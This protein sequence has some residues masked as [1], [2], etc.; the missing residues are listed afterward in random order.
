MRLEYLCDMALAYREEPLY[1]TDFVLVQPYGS[2]EGSGY[3]EMDGTV[4]GDRLQGRVRVANHPHARSDGTF[5]PN[6]HGVIVTDDQATIL[7]SL[8]GRT[9]FDGD[10]GKQLLTV[11]FE[12]ADERYRWLNMS[13]SILE[14]IKD[15]DAPDMRARSYTCVHEFS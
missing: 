7:V 11:I 10:S 13:L 15:V 5:I 1:G 8:H 12:T 3:G 4:T 9:V 6:L 2:L 14:G